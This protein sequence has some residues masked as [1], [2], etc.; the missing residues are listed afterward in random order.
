[1]TDD[2]DSTIEW[3]APADDPD[4]EP[5]HPPVEEGDDSGA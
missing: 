5:T 1:V 2:D 3:P 4:D